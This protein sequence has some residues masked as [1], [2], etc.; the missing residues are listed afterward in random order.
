MNS[1]PVCRNAEVEDFAIVFDRVRRVP[2]ETW[3]VRRC[4][5]CGFG[6]TYPMPAADQLAAFYPPTYLGDTLKTLEQYLGGRLQQ[7]RSWRGEVAKA[8]L[9]ERFVPRGR[10]LDV[11]CGDGKFLWALDA[12]RWQRTGVDHCKETLELVRRRIP[13]LELVDGDIFSGSL[14]EGFF[15][16]VTFWH[17]LEHLP[18]P[19]GV[20]GR[21]R[22]LLKTGGWLLISLPNLDS[23]QARLFRK[24]W[25]A[26][27]DVPRHL[28]HFSRSSLDRLLRDAGFEVRGYYPFSPY[29]NSHSLK[30]SLLNW[31]EDGLG[32]RVPYYALKPLL[33]GLGLLERLTGRYGI[34]TVAAQSAAF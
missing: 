22:A 19:A 3:L 16:A 1:C 10:I 6:W 4:R 8:R 28:H 9:V 34:L 18:D 27:D 23:L 12:E 31:S 15:D 17:V 25:Y 14:S 21:S 2:G 29:V 11:G 24:H 33:H 26:F 13:G 7:S 30:H 32:S 5:S 20:L